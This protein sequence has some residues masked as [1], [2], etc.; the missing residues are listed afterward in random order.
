MKILK[1]KTIRDNNIKITNNPIVYFWWFKTKSLD[2]LLKKIS[3]LYDN[4]RLKTK[5]FENENYTLLYVGQAKN[6]HHRLVKYH[7]YDSSNFHSKGVENGRLSSLRTTLCGLLDLPMSTSKN[8][9]N[10]FMDSNCVV[11][12]EVYTIDE[13]DKIEKRNIRTNYLPLNYQNTVGILTKEH[14][15]ALSEAKKKMRK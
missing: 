6:G 5:D 2:K 4:N 15:K 11:E 8:E 14:R 1:V 9:I 7:I 13:L 12:W 10:D 3:G